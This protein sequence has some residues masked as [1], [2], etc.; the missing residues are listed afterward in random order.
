MSALPNSRPKL[1]GSDTQA[2]SLSGGLL[3][4]VVSIS[5]TDTA[6]GGGTADFSSPEQVYGSIIKTTTESVNVVYI[7]LFTPMDRNNDGGA[8]RIREDDINGDVVDS[9]GYSAGNGQ[10]NIVITAI[11]KNQPV[12][13]RTYVFTR[14]QDTPTSGFTRLQSGGTTNSFVVDDTHTATLTGSN[15]QRT[16][17]NSV[18]PG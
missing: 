10:N 16:H 11:I 6:G 5:F 4:P 15:T 1:A 14:E 3:D 8:F 2:A 9:I 18:L 7:R 17:E 13:S 12:G